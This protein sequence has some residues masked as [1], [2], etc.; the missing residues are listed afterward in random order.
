[1]IFTMAFPDDE[2]AGVAGG[3]ISSNTANVEPVFLPFPDIPLT[4]AP[5]PDKRAKISRTGIE[6]RGQ[7]LNAISYVALKCKF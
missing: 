5:A 2:W 7:L 1:M 6:I 3:K 4:A